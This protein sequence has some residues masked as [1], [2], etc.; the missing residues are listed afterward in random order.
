MANL[1]PHLSIVIMFLGGLALFY[2]LVSVI[3]GTDSLIELIDRF[4]V[5]WRKGGERNGGRG[6]NGSEGKEGGRET[7]ERERGK[8]EGVR[9]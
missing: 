9:K 1:F 3:R 7:R 6:R 8:R 2:V 5:A 4:M